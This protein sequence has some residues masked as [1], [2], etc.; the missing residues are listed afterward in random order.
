MDKLPD[1][2]TID[3]T[4]LDI[5]KKIK[6]SDVKFDGITVLTSKDAII[7]SVRATRNSAK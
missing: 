6:A 4:N 5:D 2:L 3:I 7:C 1:D